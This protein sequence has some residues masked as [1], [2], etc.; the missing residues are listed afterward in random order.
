VLST[1]LLEFT[2]DAIIIWEMDGAGILYWNRAAEQLYGYT[3]EQAY[4]QTTHTLL[5]TQL[6]GG[7]QDLET[8]IALW[9]VGGRAEARDARRPTRASRRPAYRDVTAGWKMARPRG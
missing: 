7:I 2:H 3:R 8:K 1:E 5:K 4:G 6:S 9:G